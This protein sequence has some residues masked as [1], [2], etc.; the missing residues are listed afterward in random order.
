MVY[1]LIKIMPRNQWKLTVEASAQYDKQD[2]I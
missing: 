2:W 1:I